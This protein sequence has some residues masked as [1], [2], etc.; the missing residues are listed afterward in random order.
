MTSFLGYLYLQRD[1]M[2]TTTFIKEST[3][4]GLA[5]R[6]QYLFHYHHGRKHCG[7]QADMVMKKDLRVPDLHRQVTARNNDNRADLNI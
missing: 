6:F 5:S 3:S 2:T 7:V 1:T 4:L